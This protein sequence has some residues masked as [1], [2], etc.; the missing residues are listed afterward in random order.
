MAKCAWM[1]P[2][3]ALVS[4]CASSPAVDT[5]PTTLDTRDICYLK[6][7]AV[8]EKNSGSALMAQ[9]ELER[10]GFGTQDCERWIEEDRQARAAKI[11]R[12]FAIAAV[13]LAAGAAAYAAANSGGGGGGGAPMTYDREWD[14]D[15]FYNEYGQLVAYCRGVQ[16]GQF[17][18]AWRC[19]GKAQTDWRWPGK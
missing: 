19:N 17:A 11:K 3:V 5:D 1:L 8:K 6:E 14:W 18:E 7:K 12:G 15:I 4:G 9:T 13:A 10:R 16:T 2:A